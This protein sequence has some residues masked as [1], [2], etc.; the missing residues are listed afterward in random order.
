MTW[1]RQLY[2]GF[3]GPESSNLDSPRPEIAMSMT[4][5]TQ[6]EAQHR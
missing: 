2:F 6:F 5:S 3:K 4:A 1:L